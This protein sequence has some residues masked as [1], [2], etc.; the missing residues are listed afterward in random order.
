MLFYHR[1][2]TGVNVGKKSLQEQS[3]MIK[4]YIELLYAYAASQTETSTITAVRGKGKI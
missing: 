1:L 3:G 4:L 2:K